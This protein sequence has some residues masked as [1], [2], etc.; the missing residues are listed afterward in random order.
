M[1]CITP[2]VIFPKKNKDELACSLHLGETPISPNSE[3]LGD[4]YLQHAIS[5]WNGHHALPYHIYTIPNF[6][7]L[8]D[9]VAFGYSRKV[10]PKVL[11]C[12]EK[13]SVQRSMSS[14]DSENEGSEESETDK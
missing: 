5:R 12:T 11:R 9:E 3:L 8:K 6:Y 14:E 10:E 4:N 2:Y 13:S 7:N 1:S